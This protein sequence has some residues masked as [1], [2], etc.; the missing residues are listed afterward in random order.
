M[1]PSLH[2]FFYVCGIFSTAYED[3]FTLDIEKVNCRECLE[4]LTKEPK[5]TLERWRNRTVK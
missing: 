3:K 1:K 2:W 4:K 5:E